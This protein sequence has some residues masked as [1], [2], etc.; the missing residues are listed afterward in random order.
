MLGMAQQ[1][2]SLAIETS[3]RCGSAS[4]G[5]GGQLLETVQLAQ[6]H[7]HNVDLVPAIDRMCRAHGAKANTIGQV[8]IS[9]GPGSFTG[10]RVAVATAKMLAAVAGCRLV[11]VPTLEVVA[12]NRPRDFPVRAVCLGLKRGTFYAGLFHA[13]D[14]GYRLM[15][16]PT[17]ISPAQLLGEAPRPLAVIADT[18]CSL[19]G[20]GSQQRK[21][22]LVLPPAMAVPCS[23]IVWQLGRTAADQGRWTEAADLV[24]LYARAPEAAELWDL[25]KATTGAAAAVR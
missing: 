6:P 16:E 9:I 17:R 24:P 5:R 18:A 13:D 11:A 19:S 15:R 12:Q 14:A 1:P 8:Y 4:L 10:L 23:R 25:A 22:V 2:Y 21:N 3:T 7:R 20:V